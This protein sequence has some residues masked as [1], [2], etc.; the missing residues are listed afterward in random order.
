MV[1][2]IFSN[3]LV[4]CLPKKS[5]KS[6]FFDTLHESVKMN[7]DFTLKYFESKVTLSHL[8]VHRVLQGTCGSIPGDDTQHE[9]SRTLIRKEFLNLST[10]Y[11]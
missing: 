1:I 4:K 11:F 8:V 10:K 7:T 3:S 2:F 5:R 9:K 6:G